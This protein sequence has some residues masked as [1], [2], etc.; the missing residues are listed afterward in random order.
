MR[1][2]LELPNNIRTFSPEKQKEKLLQ[3]LQNFQRIVE[4]IPSDSFIE[5]FNFNLDNIDVFTSEASRCK[6][7]IYPIIREVYSVYQAQSRNN[8]Y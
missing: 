8:D 3:E 1:V 5:E 6:N 4:L 7:V 2:T